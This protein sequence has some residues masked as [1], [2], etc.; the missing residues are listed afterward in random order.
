M[1]TGDYIGNIFF[2]VW[3]GCIAR[4]AGVDQPVQ[5]GS[6]IVFS[7]YYVSVVRRP[8]YQGGMV[9]KRGLY[10]LYALYTR[11]CLESRVNIHLLTIDV[12]KS[13]NNLG[14]AIPIA[15]Y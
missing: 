11:I 4:F 3:G 6:P 9:F 8:G 7:G 13:F 14:S 12:F 2:V 5:S 10:A 1:I 15:V